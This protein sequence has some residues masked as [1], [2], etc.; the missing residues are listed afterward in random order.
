MNEWLDAMTSIVG[1]DLAPEGRFAGESLRLVPTE[2][3]TAIAAR[4]IE[5]LMKEDPADRAFDVPCNI[6]IALG[7]WD[8]RG[9]QPILAALFQRL[10]EFCE[11][12]AID[13]F[14]SR[15]GEL[16]RWLSDLTLARVTAGDPAA[17]SDY[18]SW[19]VNEPFGGASEVLPKILEPMWTRPTDEAVRK[20]A[21]TPSRSPTGS[22]CRRRGSARRSS[23]CAKSAS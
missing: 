22:K 18:G 16:R 17:L 20:A 21:K 7:R 14:G 1:E 23:A 4:R 2:S 3:V 11:A 8:A 12:T 9:S 10:R 5:V 6:A 15:A 13:R 19:I